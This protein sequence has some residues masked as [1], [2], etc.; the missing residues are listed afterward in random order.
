LQPRQ[1]QQ[2]A[3]HGQ[4]ESGYDERGRQVERHGERRSGVLG[5]PASIGRGC[6]YSLRKLDKMRAKSA[7]F[8]RHAVAAH[9][10]GARATSPVCSVT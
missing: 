10:A 1:Q 9:A 2:S 6:G 7:R 8:G 3:G 5:C 4:R